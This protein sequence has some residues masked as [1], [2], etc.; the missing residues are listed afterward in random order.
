MTA[1]TPSREALAAALCGAICEGDAPAPIPDADNPRHRIAACYEHQGAADALIASGA[2][3]PLDTLADD[4]E[5]RR[6]LRQAC[7]DPGSFVQRHRAMPGGRLTAEPLT[8]WQDRAL[9]A[10]LSERG[11]R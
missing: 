5:F 2:V 4:S 1:V 9:A 8:E 10:A 3:V 7:N 6:R 11:D